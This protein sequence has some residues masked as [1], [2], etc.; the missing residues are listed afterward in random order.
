MTLTGGEVQ[1]L[2]EIRAVIATIE[3]DLKPRLY[4]LPTHPRN[5]NEVWGE[6]ADGIASIN[7]GLKHLRAAKMKVCE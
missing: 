1:F 4:Q 6:V 3:D 5:P 7:E 2:D